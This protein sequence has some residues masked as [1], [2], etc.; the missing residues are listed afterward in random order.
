MTSKP[1]VSGV[2]AQ[3]VGVGRKVPLTESES[4]ELEKSLRT[5]IEKK[6]S[7]K[8]VAAIIIAIVVVIAVFLA[9]NY[10]L[11]PRGNS[12]EEAFTAWTEAMS[13]E[14]ARAALDT[15]VLKFA[16]ETTQT[17]EVWNMEAAFNQFGDLEITV[18]S[19]VVA[20]YEDMAP[21]MQQSLDEIM[22]EVESIYEVDVQGACVVNFNMT[23]Q[24]L[25]D[26]ETVSYTT[27]G[28][29]PFVKIDDNWYIA[30]T[31]SM[32]PEGDTDIIPAR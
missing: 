21:L 11:T 17:D 6:R 28:A 22:S 3:Q 16:D 23:S 8:K 24:Y 2:P 13:D 25:V 14:D 29:L 31:P 10:L 27:D 4:T 7:G 20:Y 15:T 1:K 18:H 5:R 32:M 12:P 30:F 26:N 9:Y 19:T